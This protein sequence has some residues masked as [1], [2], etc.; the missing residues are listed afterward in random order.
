MPEADHSFPLKPPI[1][2]FGYRAHTVV[3]GCSVFVLCV[4]AASSNYLSFFT[5][6][7]VSH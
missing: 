3:C 5:F 2:G 4:A 7:N 6:N 1:K